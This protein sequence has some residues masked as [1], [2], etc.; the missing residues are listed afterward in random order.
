MISVPMICRNSAPKI[1]LTPMGSL[2]SVMHVLRRRDRERH[3]ER[4]RQPREHP[5]GDASVRGDHPH[6]A[7]HLEALA[8]DGR[9]VAEDFGQV[10]A[11]FA[12][13]Q[14]GGHEEPGIEQLNA[15]GKRLQRIAERHAEILLVVQQPEL[16]GHR[17]RRLF[18]DDGQPGREG[19][20]R[21]QRAG[22]QIDR[23]RELL[24]ERPQTLGRLVA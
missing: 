14:H 23:L 20:A 2:M 13:R 17:L 6:L 22:N 24:L 9:Q 1:M 18:G 3:R 7:L 4:R 19:V 21:A 8:D 15:L 10:A 12:L 11:A 16:A 5:A